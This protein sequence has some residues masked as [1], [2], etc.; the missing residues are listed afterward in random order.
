MGGA[1]MKQLNYEILKRICQ[2]TR[3]DGISETILVEFET[4]DLKLIFKK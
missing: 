4:V 3:I 2:C 1:I